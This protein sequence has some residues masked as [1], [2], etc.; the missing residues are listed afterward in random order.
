MK[1]KIEV[2]T[3]ET[4]IKVIEESASGMSQ[5]QLAE[6]YKC[7]KT[8]IANIL[9]QKEQLLKEWELNGNKDFKRKRKQPNEEINKCVLDWYQNALL[10]GNPVSGPILQEK[11]RTFAVN[12]NMS[13]FRA[14]NGW[15]E[16]FRKRHGIAF[17]AVNCENKLDDDSQ[18]RKQ[19]ND[20]KLCV[21]LNTDHYEINDIYSVDETG[22]FFRAILD[23]KIVGEERK[24]FSDKL[25]KE[26]LVISLCCNAAGGKEPPLILSKS[27]HFKYF[28]KTNISN[29]GVCWKFSE[30]GSMTVNIFQEWLEELNE[31]M[32]IQNRKIVLFLDKSPS[33]FTNFVPSNIKLVFL[34]QK[35]ANKFQ[36]VEQGIKKSF[37]MFYRRKLIKTIFARLDNIDNI[38]H[39][40][41]Q[42][43]ILDAI[44]WIK[45]AWEEVEPKLII[46]CFIMCGIR[47]D[48]KESEVSKYINTETEYKKFYD[49][50]KN[51][52]VIINEDL[53][54]FEI[55]DTWEEPSI[56]VNSNIANFDPTF[57]ETQMDD[58]DSEDKVITP[59]PLQDSFT[60]IA[61]LKAMFNELDPERRHS[62]V[63]E[64]LNV[65]KEELEDIIKRK[66][67]SQI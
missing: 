41:K 63:Y 13:S 4:R 30:K 10:E 24:C 44:R 6:R 36:P 49:E 15:L 31:K 40:A 65:I 26:R 39:Q 52:Q 54:C 16:S 11:A 34:P 48:S 61:R 1:R 8:Q 2:L 58:N 38:K 3:L 5:R 25:Q 57:I 20:W 21:S 60:T 62:R 12:L 27:L 9:R 17:R 47:S 43:S 45:A 19:L 50:V 35:N 29:L 37:K 18:Q 64:S 66:I 14:S 53:Q 32:K 67:N 56:Q 33:H 51:K 22:L 28:K 42:F 7:G 46:D 55:G 23:K 59:I